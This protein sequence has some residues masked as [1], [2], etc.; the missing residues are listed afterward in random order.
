[1]REDK[2]GVTLTKVSPFTQTGFVQ[3]QVHLPK[4]GQYKKAG[5]CGEVLLHWI[6]MTKFRCRHSAF[7]HCEAKLVLQRQ[8]KEK[9]EQKSD[10]KRNMD[11]NIAVA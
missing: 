7:S 10:R 8:G 9:K 1:M 5:K 11:R 3:H 2:A 6:Q 4:N